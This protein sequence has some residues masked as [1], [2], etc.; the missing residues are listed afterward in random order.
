MRLINLRTLSLEDFI[1]TIPPYAILSHTWMN[2]EV[3]CQEMAAGGQDIS[4]KAGWIKIEEFC[5]MVVS[6]LPNIQYGWVDTC[7]I[8]K[9]SS[10]ELSEA[11][12]SM[13]AWYRN[14]ET[15]F[16]YLADVDHHDASQPL[17]QD[18]KESRWFTRGWTL[19]ELLAPNEVEFFD[20]E[21]KNFGTRDSL[22]DRIA[23]IT[24][25]DAS[26]LRSGDWSMVSAA[27]KM[28]WA[29]YRQTTRIEDQAYCLLGLFDVNMPML[30]GEGERAFLRLQEEI[31]KETDDESLLAWDASEIP[32]S[33]TTIG[34]LAPS[35]AFFWEGHS[36]ESYPSQG[37]ALVITNKGISLDT[38][39][40]EQSQ[41]AGQKLALL[42][43][44]E[45][46]NAASGIAISLTRDAF[47]TNRYS[48]SRNAPIR[49]PMRQSGAMKLQKATLVR[50]S[51]T[52]IANSIVTKCWLHY[53]ASLELVGMYPPDLWRESVVTSTATMAISHTAQSTVHGLAAFRVRDTKVC[54]TLA[55]TI[56]PSSGVGAADLAPL[57]YR[58]FSAGKPNEVM[59]MELANRTEAKKDMVLA[60][61]RYSADYKLGHARG[62]WMSVVTLSRSICPPSR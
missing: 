6:R 43:C 16:A 18:F 54:F 57:S 7:C 25:I 28:S 50:R 37:D 17:G 51:V 59:E 33:V 3:T 26:I 29:A 34:A 55:I 56:E 61:Y 38:S 40:L 47:D 24:R 60:G 48:R 30:Y 12:N 27:C 13:F 46:G 45:T 32:P 58:D 19:Q 62:P 36:F 31:L 44:S 20:G 23:T 4:K 41:L 9:T 10:A 49:I 14:A 53:M 5:K 11:I 2:G 39:L 42:S 1:G 52:S 35:P 22:A 15:C 8:D 21:W